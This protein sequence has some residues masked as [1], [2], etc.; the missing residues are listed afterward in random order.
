L[1]L[2]QELRLQDMVQLSVLGSLRNPRK[3]EMWMAFRKFCG[4]KYWFRLW[5]IQEVASGSRKVIQFGHITLPWEDI[6]KLT[7]AIVNDLR[8]AWSEIGFITTSLGN[9]SFNARLV[10]I[11]SLYDLHCMSKQGES[12]HLADLLRSTRRYLCSD[13]RDKVYGV[14][15]LAG[16]CQKGELEVNYRLSVAETFV[17]A[18]CFAIASSRKLN[19]ICEVQYL[20]SELDLPSWVP[21]WTMKQRMNGLWSRLGPDYSAAGYSEPDVTYSSNGRAITVTGCQLGTIEV[22]GDPYIEDRTRPPF[23]PHMRE[24]MVQWLKLAIGSDLNVSSNNNNTA[25]ETERTEAFWRTL[26]GNRIKGQSEPDIDLFRRRFDVARG[27]KP[28]PILNPEVDYIQ[29]FHQFVSPLAFEMN[30]IMYNRRFFTS[31][32][33]LMGVCLSKARVGDILVVLLG[34]DHPV[35]FRQE[36]VAWAFQGEA[37]VH[38]FM[39]GEAV[40][41]W[42]SGELKLNKFTIH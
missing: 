24:T 18:V 16:D 37:Y 19:I 6:G 26:I 4:C 29:A 10:D 30:A 31:G 5:I 8:H 1:E 35:I 2:I 27:V 14:L 32:Q 22:L 12:A 34:C 25:W 38:G 17:N 9:V 20:P 36:G 23:T 21:D 33:A 11:D 41:K 40:M 15:G 13:A 28:V 3:Q 7:S 42:E 39:D